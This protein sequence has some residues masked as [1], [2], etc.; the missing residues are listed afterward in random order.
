MNVRN[1]RLRGRMLGWEVVSMWG[2]AAVVIS[3]LACQ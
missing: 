2:I 3:M 1:R